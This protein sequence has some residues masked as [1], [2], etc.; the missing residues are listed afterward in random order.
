MGAGISGL[1]AARLLVSKGIR[2]VVVEKSRGVGG[3]MSTRRIDNA[4][5]DHGAQF[6]TVRDP[7][8]SRMAE[9]W[10]QAAL[11]AEWSRGFPSSSGE[12]VDGHSRYFVPHG[13]TALPKHLA[14]GLDV[15]TNSRV[16]DVS[17]AG[18]WRVRISAG[19][20]TSTK[21][22]LADG[23]ILTPPVPQSLDLLDL[24]GVEVPG[25]VRARL[26]AIRYEPCLTWMAYPT[27]ETRLPPP[28][29][30]QFS[31]GS[32]QFLADN[33]QKGISPEAAITVHTSGEFSRRYFDGNEIENWGRIV[34]QV[35]EFT[36]PIRRASFQ[37]W[38]Y[39]KPVELHP[40][41]CLPV[42]MAA[43]LV[44]CGDAFAGD[45]SGRP[46]IEGAALSGLAAARSIIGL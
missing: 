8:F 41:R 5:F 33:Q 36:G 32:L 23:L 37:R 12:G 39:A 25:E 46:R 16:A 19:T 1:L 24:G 26:D 42:D 13:M 10:A 30:L 44:F 34:G 35:A 40:E 38:R 45:S 15:H 6:V 9:E 28:G 3:R 43:P 20:P 21:E 17:F 11:I 31:S 18:T 29:A 2:V 4:V 14:I 22:L 27:S 7:E